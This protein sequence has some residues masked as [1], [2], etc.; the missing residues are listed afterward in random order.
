MVDSYPRCRTHARR[1]CQ[2]RGTTRS[3][4]ATFQSYADV[5]VHVGRGATALSL[6]RQTASEMRA[7]GIASDVIDRVCHRG[8]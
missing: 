5:A 3:M 7:D 2:Q 4:W 8:T 1:R 6:S